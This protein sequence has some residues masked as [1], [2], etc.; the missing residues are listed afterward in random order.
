MVV[1]N[2]YL[3]HL[4]EKTEMML[5]PPIRPLLSRRI[6]EAT[7]LRILLMI[8]GCLL[9]RAVETVE[10][11]QLN[12]LKNRPKRLDGV[13]L[14]TLCLGLVEVRETKSHLKMLAATMYAPGVVLKGRP[15]RL[16]AALVQLEV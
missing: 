1:T 13:M 3:L 14:R 6:T 11:S 9:Y 4:T 2:Y 15:E 5:F 12:P 16:D 7:N 10:K 8:T